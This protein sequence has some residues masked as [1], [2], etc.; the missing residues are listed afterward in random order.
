MGHFI[1]RYYFRP[2]EHGAWTFNIDRGFGKIDAMPSDP[3]D[4]NEDRVWN[5]GNA[6]IHL[7]SYS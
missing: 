4:E 3:V 7:L 1:Y 5:D 6:D 2:E